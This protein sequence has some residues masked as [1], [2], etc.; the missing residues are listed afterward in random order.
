MKALAQETS[1]RPEVQAAI[2]RILEHTQ[3]PFP[4]ITHSHLD[5][6]D[7]TVSFFL[8]C[9]DQPGL[10]T[11][12]Y[13]MVTRS[14]PGK[15]T[16]FF[17][18][19]VDE[20]YIVAELEMRFQSRMK[21][22]QVKGHVE[23]LKHELMVGLRSPY[24]ANRILELKGMTLE[25]K[26]I[27]VQERVAKTLQRFP[28]K[29]DYDFFSLVQHYFIR[30]HQESLRFHEVRQISE[31]L[32]GLYQLKRKLRQ[33]I[34]ENSGR[35]HLF[36]KVRKR[37]LHHPFGS[38]QVLGV[39]VGLNFLREHEVF[40]EKHLLKAIQALIPGVEHFAESVYE[41]EDGEYPI[42]LLYMEINS[43]EQA[44]LKRE[45]PLVLK[46]R[47][48]HLQRPL[49]MPRNEEEVMRHV[50]TLGGQLKFSRDLPQ[51]ILSF[52]GQTDKKLYFTVI[53]ARVL[54]PHLE[55]AEE[56]LEKLGHLHPQVERVKKIG[57]LRKKYFKEALVFK[58]ELRLTDF[59]R[60]DQSVD[61]YKARL[62]VLKELE[63]VVGEVRD[64]NG[65]MISKQNEV[66]SALH[67]LLGAEAQRHGLL[68]DNF[69]HALYPVEKRSLV[70][71]QDLK[72]FFTLLLEVLYKRRK[73]L[74]LRQDAFY[75]VME[76]ADKEKLLEFVEQ[77]KFS[78][79][80]VQ[81]QLMHD[82][83]FFYGLILEKDEQEIVKQLR[84]FA[85]K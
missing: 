17:L 46:G 51:I 32:A 84:A 6:L 37:W 52:H 65:G 14:L 57:M 38:R 53:L 60:D 50:V 61:L 27:R 20:T 34:E 39:S 41:Y 68:L 35:R 23:V 5:P 16:L 69:F 40:S 30:S 9:Q 75:L 77:M 19:E 13:E 15:E 58:V 47:V 80:P 7:N 36:V 22:E 45:L 67:E 74:T 18:S 21:W 62:F 83:R 11:F 8:L 4:S 3:A 54:L 66:L 78:S 82:E 81:L 33:K 63:K 49:F 26:R 55:S 25:E 73:F 10:G 2:R 42:L 29:F 31:N 1:H 44:L 71:P 79:R 59:L 76:V 70:P 56:L 24:H 43:H 64:Y 48:E 12:F 72:T 28:E 85:I